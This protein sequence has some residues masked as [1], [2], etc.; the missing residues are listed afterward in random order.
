MTPEI[1]AF[2]AR[3]CDRSAD[4]PWLVAAT[5]LHTRRMISVRDFEPAPRFGGRPGCRWC[6][7]DLGE[8]PA[9]CRWHPGCSTEWERRSRHAHELVLR[10]DRGVCRGCGQ[11]IGAL[12]AMLRAERAEAV[13]RTKGERAR[14]YAEYLWPGPDA[15]YLEMLASWDLTDDRVRSA[16]TLGEVDHH[17]PVW[18][19]GGVCGLDNLR[20]LCPRCHRAESRLGAAARAWLSRPPVVMPDGQ[21]PLFGGGP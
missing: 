21:R 17:C 1:A 11:D 13:V 20:L 8:L 10:R 6:H 16:R 15:R 14:E 18:R 4:P 2:L 19:G 5:H 9:N 3:T 12:L 7:G